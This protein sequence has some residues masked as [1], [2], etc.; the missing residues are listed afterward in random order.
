[1]GLVLKV[2]S[3]PHQGAEFDIPDEEIA[4]GAAD[5]C[6]VII[7][8]VLVANRHM[9]LKIIDGRVFITPLEGNVFIAG[10][11]L[12]EPS[13]I[14]N[15]QFVTIGATHMM[16]G[17][18]GGEQWQTV[19]LG[20]FP[21]LEKVEEAVST[22]EETA[23]GNP[24]TAEGTEGKDIKWVI[25]WNEDGTPKKKGFVADPEGQL[26]ET[27]LTDPENK[28]TK[29]WRKIFGSKR[30]TWWQIIVRYSIIFVL[31]LAIA[32]GISIAVVVFS[33]KGPVPTPPL[34]LEVCIQNAIDALKIKEKI[35]ISK[36]GDEPIS[37]VGYVDRMEDSV[38]IKSALKSISEDISIKLL[39]MEKILSS[40]TE[41]VKESKQNVTLK[42]AEEFGELIATGYVRKEEIWTKLKSEVAAIKGITNIKDE[43]LTKDSITELTK[44]VL[45]R[46]KFQDKLT[47]TPNDE[48]VEI[49]GTIADSD[50]DNWIKTR[51]DF[52]KT[53]KK[54]AQ[55]SFQISV[56]TDRNL[57]IEKFFGGQI[58]SVN[59]NSQ[60]L[61]WVNIKGGTKYFQGSVLPSGYVIDRVEQ[62]SV[63]IR[64]ADEVVTLD[65][66]WV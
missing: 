10:K 51:E 37:V 12:R 39:V 44:T 8:D 52:E 40:A 32:T 11:L 22:F 7:S 38:A 17:E 27:K 43:V 4:I 9:Q 48:G 6:D 5:D 66:N 65:L 19:A 30:L 25:E 21:E 47:I 45:E 50:K 34:P 15:F 58:D 31:C 41:M 26:E 33:Q 57:T 61:D 28:K 23:E 59:F 1:M 42:Q 16:F 55:V 60:G 35:K 20:D 36:V 64:N 56:S 63:T 3:G 62:D 49:S 53:F 24:E 29:F 14:D 46:H 2:L 54:K 13:A 18:N